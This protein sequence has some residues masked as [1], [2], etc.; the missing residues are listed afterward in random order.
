VA[1]TVSDDRS[2]FDEL[3]QSP[4]GEPS[5][6]REPRQAGAPWP[7]VVG[8]AIGAVA[9]LAGYLMASGAEATPAATTAGV[10]SS[11]TTSTTTAAASVDGTVAFPPGFVPI[12][13]LLAA[14]PEYAF[15]LG[16]DLVVGF[17]TA[18]RRGFEQTNGFDG[19]DWVLET[20]AGEQ[21]A[22]VGTT[23]DFGVPGN[24]SVHFPGAAESVPAGVKLVSL[25]NEDFRA[26]SVDVPWTGPPFETGGLRI[27][28]DDG[29]SVT[30]DRITLDDTSGE[31]AWSIQGVDGPGGLV[32]V[33]ISDGSV[34]NPTPLYYDSGGS[35][36]PFGIS[37]LA[38]AAVQGVETLMPAEG[39]GDAGY[40]E[41][42]SVDVSLNLVGSTPTDAEFDL[43]GLPGLEH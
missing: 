23:F 30:L 37:P 28:F 5:A 41:V 32:Q 4:F 9:V 33:F 36:D 17:T 18:T 3:L 1:G 27:Q 16:D 13:E 15:D 2:P 7:L 20:A 10:A 31:V 26:S 34:P 43:A 21:I 12:T 42:L 19:G 22:A 25:W 38:G 40:P 11:T 8:I 24:F 6:R 29:I 39:G 35:F 14:K